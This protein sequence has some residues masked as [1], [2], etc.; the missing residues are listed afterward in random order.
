MAEKLWAFIVG[1][2][3]LILTQFKVVNYSKATR[4]AGEVEEKKEIGKHSKDTEKTKFY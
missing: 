1:E 3:T 2:A 4:Q